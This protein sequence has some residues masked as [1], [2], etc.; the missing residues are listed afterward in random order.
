MIDEILIKSMVCS[1]CIKVINSEFKNMGINVHDIRLGKVLISF[2]D[3]VVTKADILRSLQKNDFEIIEDQATKLAEKTRLLL[4]RILENGEHDGSALA[5]IIS[6]MLGV[7]YNKLNTTYASVFGRTI[8]RYWIILRI[9]KAKELIEEG[10]LTFGEI[11]YRLGY[12]MPQSLS[13][14]F[15]D[16]TG[17]SMT[18][19]KKLKPYNRLLI[20]KI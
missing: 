15:K 11:A 13:R 5:T 4:I 18:D 7:N 2:D 1:R 9:E 8:E 3:S 6:K 20:D 10:E 12:K 16:E 19:Y 14:R 17:L